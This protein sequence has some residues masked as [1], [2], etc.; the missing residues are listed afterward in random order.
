MPSAFGTLLFVSFLV[1][2][3]NEISHG[4]YLG[5]ALACLAVALVV[6]AWPFFA[7]SRAATIETFRDS[8]LCLGL[9]WAALASM[10]ITAWLDP[11][12]IE[13][14]QG[15]LT[16]LRSLEVAAVPLLMTYLPRFGDKQERRRLRDMR[17]AAFAVLTLAT[18]LAVLR[19]S[20][21][22]GI[23][24]WDIQ[25]RAAEA[26][27]RGENPYATVMVPTS[28]AALYSTPTH[29]VNELPFVYG[30]GTFCVG[31]LGLLI[32]G[33]VRYAMLLALLATGVSFRIIA[34]S[35]ASETASAAPALLEDAPALF[36]WLM[37]L[38][39]MIIELSWTDPVQLVFVAVATLA[40][41]RK[42][43]TLAAVAIGLALVSKQ[44]MFWLFPLAGFVLAFRAR[45]WAVTVATAVVPLGFFAVADYAA[46]KHAVIDYQIG[47]PPR[48]DALCMAVW[49][50]STFGVPWPSVVATA[51]G[52]AVVGTA[53]VRARSF[54]P[55][56][57]N[58][59]QERGALFAYAAA[60]AYFT[61]FFFNKWAFANY[62]F[63]VAGLAAL[64]AAT[65]LAAR[66][67]A[68]ATK[69]S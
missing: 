13:H 22:P 23:D 11:K 4:R 62:Y 44:S 19:T 20:P 6:L 43:P 68:T 21:A 41:L 27:L 53:L 46:F 36:L 29:L 55:G 17:F 61:F 14:P 26:V 33:D 50:K 30:P 45:D 56:G 40:H 9:T 25:M 59:T 54:L 49:F 5:P 67:E 15:T 66:R 63:F 65:S 18:G 32:G 35:R 52:A 12:I 8:K 60:L 64:A 34:R 31:A 7:R 58:A 48:D 47:L 10:P 69:P 57:A 39:A 2:F 24:V 3:A 28:S 37:P 42:H 38:L 51:G 16:A 1:S